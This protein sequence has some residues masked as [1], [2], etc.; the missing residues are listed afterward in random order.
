[1]F[2]YQLSDKHIYI[3]IYIY[4]KVKGDYGRNLEFCNKY[5]FI[6]STN[7]KHGDGATV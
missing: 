4:Y 7:D 5:L 3:Y 1:M 2:L 6:M